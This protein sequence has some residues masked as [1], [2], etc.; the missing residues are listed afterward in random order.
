[1]GGLKSEKDLELSIYEHS[2][3][4][5]TLLCSLPKYNHVQ[6][7]PANQKINENK[8]FRNGKIM[9]K[10]T[11]V[12]LIIRLKKVEQFVGILDTEKNVLLALMR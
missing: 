4:N 5:S 7:Q 11:G 3:K 6:I 2:F 9:A 10:R 1:M 8:N 12:K